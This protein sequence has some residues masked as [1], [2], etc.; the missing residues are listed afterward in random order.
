MGRTIK[1]NATV[2][3]KGGRKGAGYSVTRKLP[4]PPKPKQQGRTPNTRLARA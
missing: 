3:I 2:G 1:V 4:S